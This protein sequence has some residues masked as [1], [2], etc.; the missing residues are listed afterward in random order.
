MSPPARNLCLRLL[1]LSCYFFLLFAPIVKSEDTYPAMLGHGYHSLKLEH[2]LHQCASGTPKKIQAREAVVHFNKVEQ[3]SRLNNQF[4]FLIPG[5]IFLKSDTDLGRFVLRTRDTEKSSTYLL[6]SKVVLAREVLTEAE[7]MDKFAAL[8]IEEFEPRCGT[9]FVSL[10]ESGGELHVAF[11]FSFANRSDKESFEGGG[12]ITSVAGLGAHVKSLNKDVRKKS[13]IEIFFHQV[14]GKIDHLEDMFESK[15]IAAC[16]LESFSSCEKLLLDIWHYATDTFPKA[17]QDGHTESI[18]F[19]ASDYPNRVVAYEEP[20]VIR[21]RKHLLDLLESHLI[22]RDTI[23]TLSLTP[24]K[25]PSC[26]GR[27][28]SIISSQISSNIREVKEGIKMSFLNPRRFLVAGLVE[29]IELY[30]YTIP[31]IQELKQKKIL[32]LIT[33]LS[34]LSIGAAAACLYFMLK[35]GHIKTLAI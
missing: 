30:S 24:E 13:S 8:P 4:N 2:K 14:G 31:A 20:A 15:D 22:D 1:W 23:T 32:G 17:L 3:W 19:R 12:A 9:Q 26:D 5:S 10:I 18:F 7:L 29:H 33:P 34:A 25:T 16:S 21:G 27:C 6:N 11:K 28:L 35:V